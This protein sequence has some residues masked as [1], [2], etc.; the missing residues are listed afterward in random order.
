MGFLRMELTAVL[1]VTLRGM[2]PGKGLGE[3][4]CPR[5]PRRPRARPHAW[6]LA[7]S[8]TKK[9]QS[10]LGKGLRSPKGRQLPIRYPAKSYLPFSTGKTDKPTLMLPLPGSHGGDK[11]L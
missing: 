5:A 4:H 3:N 6:P 11:V 7:L 10:N 2:V 8:T 1:G 9:L